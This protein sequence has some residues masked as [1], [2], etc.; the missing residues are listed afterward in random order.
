MYQGCIVAA[1]DTKVKDC[2]KFLRSLFMNYRLYIVLLLV[3]ISGCGLGN[4]GMILKTPV[5]N[6]CGK[7][8]LK[9]CPEITEGIILYAQGNQEGGVKKVSYGL[10]LNVENKQQL[11]LFA[12][13]VKNLNSIPGANG[14]LAKISPIIDLINEN[15]NSA[16]QS[17][18][19]NNKNNSKPSNQELDQSDQEF[20][21][22]FDAVNQEEMNFILPIAGSNVS[23]VQTNNFTIKRIIVPS[24]CPYNVWILN[25]GDNVVWRIWSKANTGLDL[26]NLN[27]KLKGNSSLIVGIIKDVNASKDNLELKT[28][29][30]CGVL[31]F[32]IMEDV[33]L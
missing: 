24:V 20:N 32:K 19:Q 31:V 21:Q 11:L 17:P 33:E 9:G 15:A 30:R 10:K 18:E 29:G 23:L 25:T 5:S 22:A 27:L 7:Y 12:D 26:Q 4:P 6:V 16:D 3:F 1:F 14:I 28:D 13:A 8:N 2:Y